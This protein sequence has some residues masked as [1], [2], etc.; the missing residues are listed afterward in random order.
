MKADSVEGSQNSTDTKEGGRHDTK[1]RVSVED[2]PAAPVAPSTYPVESS[3]SAKKT[4]PGHETPTAQA[5]SGNLTVPAVKPVHGTN[6]IVLGKDAPFLI[7]IDSQKQWYHEPAIY[8]SAVA[9]IVS[10]LSLWIN[11][12]VGFQKDKRARRQSI[13]D[14]FFLRKVLYP[15]A[16]EPALE[17][18]AKML[19]SL[20]A[21]RFDPSATAKAVAEF[22]A[23]FDKENSVIVAKMVTLGILG[24]L[25]LDTVRLELE[26]IEDLVSEY[27]FENSSGY[28]ANATTNSNTRLS[29]ESQV[30][31]HLVSVLKAVRVFQESVR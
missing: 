13:E 11:L 24:Q 25:L 3:S 14:E 27:C 20:P 21:D 18:Y 22:K 19:S 2:V 28:E 4:Q 30:S 16:I 31:G 9:I 12:R 10:A 23:D 15:L 1:G 7:K 29:V 26:A 17:H 8:F 5:P 6:A